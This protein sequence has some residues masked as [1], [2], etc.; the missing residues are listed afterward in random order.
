M[1]AAVG[2]PR[3]S[4][5]RRLLPRRAD[6]AG[7]RRSWARDLAAGV[8][9]GVVALPLALGFGVAS[10]VGAAPGLV[11]AVIAG[12]VAAVFG[13]SS[14]QVSGP[15]GAMTVVL[16]PLVAAHGPGVVVPVAVMAGVLVVAAAVL[17]MGRLLAYVP[18]PLVEGFTVG[19]A[20]VIAAQQ[21]PS[22][23][24]LPQ[25]EIEN[26]LAA[27]ASVVSTF[28][29]RPDWTVVGLLALAV[30]LTAVLPRLH[31]AVPASLLAVAAVTLVVELSG[32]EVPTIGELPSSLPMPALPDFGH[33]GDL[34]GAAVVV[35]FLAALE[36]LL[37][38]RVADGMIDAPRH[39]PDRELFGQGLANVAS[40]LFGG[41]PATGA[42]ART[43][44]NARAG[45]R[46]RVAAL[47]H[48]VVLAA[49]VYAASGAVGRI[50][51]V[52]LA[53]VLL[54]TAY[55]MVERH[56]VR[57]VLTST[58][59][60]A[61][62]FL[63]TAVATVAIDL[64]TA[65]AVG[66][67]AAVVLAVAR[68]GRTA[69]V[70][71]EETTD[72]SGTVE[73]AL[74]AERVLTYRLDGPLFFAVADRLLREI[75]ATEDVDVVILRAGSVAMLDATGAHALGRVIE[76]LER[77]GITVLVKVAGEE[78]LRLLTAVGALRHLADRGH[79]FT[80][81]ADAVAHAARHVTPVG[82]VQNPR[83]EAT[84]DSGTWTTASNAS[85]TGVAR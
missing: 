65:V 50:P 8:T 15:T 30:A 57:A 70:V 48:A 83:S 16:V 31:R 47:T 12:A 68:L 82:P 78:Q 49:I 52:A 39:D 21:V 69:R 24:G 2:A 64:V 37:S 29:A 25:P 55:R 38:A 81:L 44:V 4:V 71:A 40:G 7:L 19:I 56:T 17:G 6:Y 61:A 11:T 35:A 43:A 41:L 66:L 45:A 59:G 5:L 42:I 14:L 79:V 23:L 73:R 67:A 75:A 28:A 9:V 62:V 58:R 27:A 1:T 26:A 80:G 18:W 74:L 60:D 46:T 32:V 53:G 51:L 84:V 20:V 10:G 63:L 77:R 72:D 36:S 13:G 54:V 34:V 22:A 85:D 3:R 76:D 33:A